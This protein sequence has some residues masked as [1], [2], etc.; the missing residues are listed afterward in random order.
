MCAMNVA[1]VMPNLA[2]PCAAVFT[3]SGKTLRGGGADIRLPPSVRGLTSSSTNDDPPSS[4]QFTGRVYNSDA[5]AQRLRPHRGAA[6]GHHRGS[7]HQE[8][9]ASRGPQR[10]RPHYRCQS[11]I[12]TPE[13]RFC[14]MSNSEFGWTRAAG[15]GQ[16]RKI[17][18]MEKFS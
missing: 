10:R 12:G 17:I 3:L 8:D 6:A 14:P 5:D 9:H 7:S 13:F 1:I 15:F 11:E 2:A 4:E 18:L 16:F